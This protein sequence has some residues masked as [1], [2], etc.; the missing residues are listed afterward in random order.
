MPR[1]T[2]TEVRYNLAL[3]YLYSFVDY[4]LKH[5]SELA[6]ADFNLSRMFALMESLRNPQAKHPIIHVAGTKGKGSVSA[7]CASALQAGGYRVGLYTS[8]H[9]LDYTERI[10]IDGKR[11]SHG[12][13]VELVEE[14]KPFVAKIEKL[15]TFEITTALAFMAFAKADVDAAVF[16]VGLGGRLDATNVVTPR[17][18]VITSLS[19]DHM[20]VLGNTLASIAGEKAGIIKPGVPV[21]SGLQ[22]NEALEVLLRV[23]N[24]RNS[25]LT[26]VGRDVMFKRIGSSLEGQSFQLSL[27]SGKWSEVEFKIPLL[28]M[29][30][31]ENAATAYAALRLCGI[32]LSSKDIQN[33]FANVRWPARFEVARREPP[34]IFDSAHN[35]ESFFR[36]REALEEYFPGRQVYLIFG[37]SE[38]KNIPGM[39]LE[40]K[41]KIKELIVTRADHPRAL[42]PARIQELARQAEVPNEAVSPVHAALVRALELAEKDGSI[43]LSAGSMFVTAEVMSAWNKLRNKSN[44]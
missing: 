21:V 29:H 34:V 15:T 27:T 6:K 20:A 14:I 42:E 3:D 36:L 16:E 35:Q 33:G 24:E 5:S 4:S 8:P 18:S 19:Y 38:D 41:S 17:V 10:Q 7:L 44:E 37:A 9:L 23:A 22:K 31:V 25:P 43:V 1:M 32:R 28:G 39:F 26:L 13:L 30:Q 2:D 11:I 12:L 40:M